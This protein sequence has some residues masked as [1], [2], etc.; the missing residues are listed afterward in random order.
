MKPP[1]RAAIA[2]ALAIALSLLL[3]AIGTAAD[4]IAYP[5]GD[6]EATSEKFAAIHRAV[7]ASE[8]EARRAAAVG[9]ERTVELLQ[10]LDGTR[11]LAELR[12]VTAAAGSVAQAMDF[13]EG[14]PLGRRVAVTEAQ[15][16]ALDMPDGTP[17]QPDGTVLRLPVRATGAV[18]QY[19]SVTGAKQTVPLV[20][21]VST[22]APAMS[23]TDF[24]ERL[25]KGEAWTVAIG[26]TLEACQR[27][28][29]FGRVPEPD[30][31]R[32]TG[33]G[34]VTCP[35]CNGKAKFEV[36]TLYRIRW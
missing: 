13:L 25:K 29:G 24:V 34:K 11:Y 17:V 26:S 19:L 31:S 28:R 5:V 23:L 36:P 32:R 14:R 15:T 21:T 9:S 2:R 7:L 30:A 18:H 12:E 35:H 27:C 6:I 33:D 20:A 22:A 3:P 8:G 10:H 16:V 4:P 1:L